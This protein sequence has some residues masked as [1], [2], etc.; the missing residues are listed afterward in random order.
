MDIWTTTALPERDQ[1]SYW[2]EVLCEAYV[3]LNPTR[4]SNGVFTGTVKAHPLSSINVTTISSVQQ[5]IYRGPSEI[6][7]MPAEVY[8]LNL[9]VKGQC[10]MSQG[11][12]EAIVEPGDFAIVDSTEPYLNDYFS[13]E[14]E[15]HSF[16]IP[17]HLL[18]PR[19]Q[20]P[21]RSCA[22]RIAGDSGIGKVVVDYL[23]S[24]ARNTTQSSTEAAVLGSSLID[25][26]A[27]SLGATVNAQ[28]A[29]KANA[30]KAMYSSIINHI[31]MN[32]TDPDLSPAK[33]ATHFHLSTRYLHKILE[34]GGQSF[35]RILLDKRL[36]R[37]ALD[38]Q[39]G[40]GRSISE[41]G[42]RWG[43][44]DLSHFSRT[45]RQRFGMTPREYKCEHAERK[46]DN[47][48]V[49]PESQLILPASCGG[50]EAVNKSTIQNLPKEASN[51]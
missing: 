4:T 15:Q 27:L 1:F 13:D 51:K 31:A 45:F 7:K 19:L 47:K 12:R 36:E 9:Q 28:D 50:L 38:L 14:W 20:A 18:R 29:G 8:F 5:K 33:V 3:A 44:N 32:A 43:F 21:Q 37:C 41:I 2:R 23:M 35:G 6:S 49:K 39:S 11:G 22:V 30:R 26:V 42:L 48:I 16:R 10:R 24:V 25:L 40:N 17:Q 46:A 34:D